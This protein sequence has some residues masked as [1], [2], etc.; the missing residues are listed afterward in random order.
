MASVK[1]LL[2]DKALLKWG[3]VSQLMMLAEESSEL[4]VSALHMTRNL[5]NK[6]KALESLAEEIADVQ[7]MIDEILYYFPELPS[8]VA[9]N[10]AHKI[11]R[12]AE[13]LK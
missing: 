9:I 11:K 6:E 4:S 10:Q 13:F 3:L 8:K 1:E 12:L 2:Y 7:L 5:K